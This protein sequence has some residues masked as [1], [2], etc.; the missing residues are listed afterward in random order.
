VRCQQDGAGHQ[1]RVRG[2]RDKAPARR[3]AAR[4]AAL[5]CAAPRAQDGARE[6]QRAWWPRACAC[7]CARA[8]ACACA[9]GA[10]R[11]E[12][13][14]CVGGAAGG[15]RNTP[16]RRPLRQ[17]CLHFNRAST[18]LACEHTRRCNC[19]AHRG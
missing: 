7:A 14:A 17:T 16:A 13:V 10:L 4:C 2:A 19:T 8:C 3:L 15:P 9:V 18:P 12:R 5:R 6:G 1:G 11:A